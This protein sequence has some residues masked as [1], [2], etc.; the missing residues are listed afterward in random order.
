M[1]SLLE[2]HEAG[3]GLSVGAL[4]TPAGLAPAPPGDDTVVES[5]QGQR[6]GPW[7]ITSL[8][9]RGGMGDVWLAERADHAFEGQAAIKVL[10]RGMDSDSVLARFAL[11]QRS[12]AR[13]A[14]PHIAR[15]LDA[16]R[17]A[18]GL[19]Y[20]VMERVS[21]RPIHEACAGLPLAERL[22]LFLQLT[23]AVAHAHRNLLVHR[24]LKPG[25]VMVDDEGQ[26]KL[27][28][29]GIA[30]ALDPAPETGSDGATADLT[31]AGERPFTPHYA[32]PEQVS[33]DP[34]TTATDIYSLGVLLY[35]LLTG[36]RPTGR[37]ATTPAAVARCVLEE[38]PTKPSELAPPPAEP[39]SWPLA[40]RKLRGDLDT[41][42]LK[43]LAKEPGQRYASVDA[44]AADLRAH[45]AGEP[46]SARPATWHYVLGRLVARRPVAAAAALLGSLT[47]LLALATALWQ[48]D[49]AERARATAERRFSQV[50]QLARDLIFRH[51]D[52]VAALAGST[53]VREAML[54][55]AVRF[56]DGLRGEGGERAN[57][58][59]AREVAEGYF[60]V[61]V[62]LGEQHSPSQERLH[63]AAQHLQR[64]LDLQPDYV[65]DPGIDPAGLFGAADMWLARTSL[66]LRAARLPQALGALQQARALTDRGVTAHAAGAPARDAASATAVAAAGRLQGLSRLAT[67]EGRLGQL[68]GGSPIGA[69]LGRTQEA[70]PHLRRS[71]ELM[72]TLVAEQP[73]TAEWMHQSAWAHQNLVSLLVLTG[74]AGEALPLAEAMIVLRDEAARLVPD[75]AHFRHQRGSVRASQAVVLSELGRHREALLVQHEVLSLMQTTATADAANRSAVRDAVLS[76]LA[77]GRIHAMAGDA[78]AARPLLQST[79]DALPAT[80]EMAAGSDFYLARMRSEALLWLARALPRAEAGRARDLAGEVR[81]LMA[82]SDDNAA[83]RWTL[84]L[85]LGEQARAAG[86]LGQKEEAAALA[87]QALAEWAAAAGGGAPAQYRRWQQRDEVLARALSDVARLSAA[88]ASPPAPRPRSR[89]PAPAPTARR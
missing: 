7:R 18:D 12:L 41:I 57:P 31:L 2:H 81:R 54:A 4:A 35:V 21:G 77:A 33:G 3:A 10:R 11:E 13:L 47:V 75:N 56:L 58:A 43:A 67:V 74:R 28:D 64:A 34:I 66:E 5:R 48:A 72:Q 32:S 26:V 29:F 39:A 44:L 84:A 30:K 83:R 60:R 79:L 61:A 15:L 22:R 14:H 23:D 70:E 52:R 76:R 8:L 73:G 42:A 24:D 62:L 88:P 86:D 6:L 38:R 82:G 89:P 85:A 1:R 45:L 51:H 17:S 78:A 27:L 55:D 53:A 46:I 49:R 19:P 9:G 36:Q 63:E 16:G 69:N 87:R 50:R 37:G 20:F 59:L 80:A 25:N 40:R 65:N 68:L 71:L